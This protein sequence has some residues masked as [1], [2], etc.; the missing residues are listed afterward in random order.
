MKPH[1]RGYPIH[2]TVHAPRRFWG[3]P[4]LE[5]VV[6]VIVNGWV[7]PAGFVTDGASTPRILWP[8]IH[9]WG[10]WLKAAIL[11]DWLLTQGDR[12]HADHEFYEALVWCGVR[13]PLAWLMWAGVR[14]YGLV[15]KSH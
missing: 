8:V 10:K 7:V 2:A 9:P 15:Q 14:A 3:R 12:E 5:I 1:E 11:H 13:R 6:P 4:T